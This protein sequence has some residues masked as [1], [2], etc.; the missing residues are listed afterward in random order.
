LE[1]GPEKWKPHNQKSGPAGRASR[2]YQVIRSRESTMDSDK[3]KFETDFY[4]V[5]EARL[6]TILKSDPDRDEKLCDALSVAWEIHRTAPESVTPLN[7]AYYALKTVRSN[8]HQR[9][10]TLSVL[11]PK[12][13]AVSRADLDPDFV[14]RVGDDPATIA[15]LRIDFASWRA[16][17]TET[18]GELVELLMLGETT[19]E[20]AEKLGCSPGNVSQY[21]KRL[22]DSWF[23]R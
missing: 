9:E 1:A 10:S 5:I 18:Q 14:G 21:R 17:L 4:P 19:K 12:Q 6:L 16:S 7:V 20:A 15:M 11:S 22:A 8:K 3:S 2:A 23:A 13:R